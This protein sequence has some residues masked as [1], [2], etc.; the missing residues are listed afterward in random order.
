M[1]A[2]GFFPTLGAIRAMGRR[3]LAAGTGA[4]ARAARIMQWT[5]EPGLPWWQWGGAWSGEVP[6]WQKRVG[7][8]RLVIAVARLM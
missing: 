6:R 1:R 3:R 4:A 2:A 5:G 7:P 8:P